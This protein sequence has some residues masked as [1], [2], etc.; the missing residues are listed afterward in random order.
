MDE[1]L[2]RATPVTR[3]TQ[4]GRGARRKSG[5]RQSLTFRDRPLLVD[6][7]REKLIFRAFAGETPVRCAVTIAAIRDLSGMSGHDPLLASVRFREHR[8]FVQGIIVGKYQAGAVEEDG[9]IL[10]DESD[11]RGSAERTSGNY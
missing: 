4:T 7:E 6:A 11:V 2:A 9:S 10:I 3:T 5:S 1:G 8:E